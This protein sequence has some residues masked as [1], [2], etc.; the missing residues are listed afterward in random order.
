MR[1]LIT[2]S[3]GFLGVNLV[4]QV[5][6]KRPDWEIFGFDLKSSKNVNYNYE[7]LNFNSDVN[8]KK[9][10]KAIEPDVIFHLVGLFRGTKEEMYST[11]VSSFQSFI[12]G[13]R[14]SELESRL[15]VLGS[16]AQYGV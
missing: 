7:A 6:T 10:L 9:K 14:D 15:L 5:Q 13:F 2:G 1:I 8:W 4:K 16:S 11:N 12:E 3:R